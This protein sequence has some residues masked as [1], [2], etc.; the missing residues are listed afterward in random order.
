MLSCVGVS[1]S[2]WATSRGRLLWEMPVN[3]GG[4]Y[5]KKYHVAVLLGAR[6]ST[7]VKET[8]YSGGP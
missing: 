4:G 8:K 3:F 1:L 6:L 5:F 2:P 7:A